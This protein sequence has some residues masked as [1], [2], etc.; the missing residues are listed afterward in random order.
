MA[1]AELERSVRDL[2]LIGLKLMPAAQ[3]FFLDDRRFYPLWEKCVELA[4]P[5]L[6]HTGTTGLGSGSAGGQGLKLKY[7]RPIPHLDDLAADFPELTIIAAHPGWPWEQELLAVAL[8][9]GNVYIDLSGWK[10]QY[11]PKQVL[12]YANTL[13]QD[14]FLFGSDYPMLR[15]TYLLDEF[16]KVPFK[17][18]VRDKF[19]RGNALKL[20]PFWREACGA[21]VRSTAGGNAR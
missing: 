4:I 19:L 10:P 18:H 17:P 8:H 2:G 20:F 16:D 9:K 12:Q 5:I 3:G 21:N 7:N 6:T 14:K 1:L 11:I 13:L 15:P